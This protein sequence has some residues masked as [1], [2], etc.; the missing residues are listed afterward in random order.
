MQVTD[1]QPI[2]DPLCALDVHEQVHELG[3][4]LSNLASPY[5]PR[6]PELVARVLG[7]VGPSLAEFRGYWER[8]RYPPIPTLLR[9]SHRLPPNGA[10]GPN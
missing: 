3:N 8:L 10:S 1:R 6:Y 9:L 2:G 7:T 4:G 5:L